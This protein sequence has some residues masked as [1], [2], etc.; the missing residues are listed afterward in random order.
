MYSNLAEKNKYDCLKLH[1]VGYLIKLKK[2]RLFRF[3]FIFNGNFYFEMS[4]FSSHYL[5]DI[6]LYVSVK[7]LYEFK[8]KMFWE[9]Y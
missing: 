6:Y 5:T 7:E 8:F 3:T 1:H 2:I 4:N 9:R